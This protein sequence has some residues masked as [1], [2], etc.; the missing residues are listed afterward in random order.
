MK[1][2]DANVLIAL[3][4]PDHPHHTAARTWLARNDSVGDPFGA[5]DLCWVATFRICTDRRVFAAPSTS[6]DMDSFHSSV[7]ARRNY[8]HIASASGHLV[9]T[10]QLMDRHRAQGSL[11]NDAYLAAFSDRHGMTIVSFDRDFARFVGTRL[12]DPSQAPTA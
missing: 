9:Q 2:L 8:H 1:L 3:H 10:L 6:A 4:R 7:V 11:T 12:I 5:P